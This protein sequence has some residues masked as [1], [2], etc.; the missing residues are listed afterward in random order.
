MKFK[1]KED[2]KAEIGS[3]DPFYALTKGG[4]LKPESILA[5]PK[6]ANAVQDAA[7]LVEAFIDACYE[8]EVIEEF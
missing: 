7:D 4:Y 6:Q 5:D 1:F 3:E 2:A 8:E